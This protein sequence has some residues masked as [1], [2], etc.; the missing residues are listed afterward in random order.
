MEKDFSTNKQNSLHGCLNSEVNTSPVSQIQKPMKND[1]GDFPMRLVCNTN[2]LDV[3]FGE[4]AC[5]VLEKS[6]NEN[7]IIHNAMNVK[8]SKLLT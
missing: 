5:L 8:S 4:L 1:Q 7:N 3:A 2:N 6:F